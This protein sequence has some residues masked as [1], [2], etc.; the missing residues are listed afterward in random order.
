VER[1]NTKEKV[2]V[3]SDEILEDAS[4]KR[5]RIIKNKKE[6]LEKEYR[7]LQKELKKK[8][9]N[10]LDRSRREAEK[11]KETIITRAILNKRNKLRQKKQELFDDLLSELENK[12]EE[13]REELFYINFYKRLIIEAIGE[14]KTN[15][16]IIKIYTNDYDLIS[17]EF[18][19]DINNEFKEKIIEYTKTDK[20][21]Y[22]GIL[23]CSKNER[24]IVE[25]TLRVKIDN[26]E[27]EIAHDL[28]MK[29][30]DIL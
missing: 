7:E 29:L 4:K 20:L 25:N 24:E 14:I 13:L 6:R 3:I 9:S 28:S 5:D 23:A 22:P 11:K 1:M 18:I 17:T 8:K 21:D 2:T 30:G 16:I 10:I 12:F 15:K 26:I 19:S 27:D